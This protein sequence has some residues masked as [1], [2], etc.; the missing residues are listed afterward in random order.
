MASDRIFKQLYS[1]TNK[2]K[3]SHSQETLT[4]GIHNKLVNVECAKASNSKE[5]TNNGSLG[6]GSGTNTKEEVA[7]TSPEEKL[8]SD[9]DSDPS[10]SLNSSVADSCSA[11][12]SSTVDTENG[13]FTEE[14][15]P[16]DMDGDNSSEFCDFNA[17]VESES[18]PNSGQLRTKSMHESTNVQQTSSDSLSMEN[19]NKNENSVPVCKDA[20]STAESLVTTF[21]SLSTSVQPSTSMSTVSSVSSIDLPSTSS[22]ETAIPLPPPAPP[23]LPHLSS[24]RGCGDGQVKTGGVMGGNQNEATHLPFSEAIR[25]AASKNVG[26]TRDDYDGLDDSGDRAHTG[27]TGLDNLG[28]TCYL[29][30]IVQCLAN[31]RPLRDYFLGEPL[32]IITSTLYMYILIFTVKCSLSYIFSYD[33]IKVN[34]EFV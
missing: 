33:I 6:N 27:L 32:S 24:V 8:L 16:S 7:K 9:G 28:N 29:N 10:P 13:Q 12:G 34:S 20:T 1:A 11:C 21:S 15:I 26:N 30:S 23:S 3:I 31:T 19:E 22:S 4:N 25:A 2:D 14:C 5:S 18:T 17:Y